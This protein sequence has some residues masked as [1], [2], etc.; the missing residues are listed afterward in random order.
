M[1]THSLEWPFITLSPSHTSLSL[2]HSG[3]FTPL[4]L[5]SVLVYP[6]NTLC[7]VHV[8]LVCAWTLNLSFNF[9]NVSLFLLPF[10]VSRVSRASPRASAHLLGHCFFSL[11]FSL[12]LG[13]DFVGLSA[14]SL[15][16]VYGFS[17]FKFRIE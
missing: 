10:P 6:Y 3:L 11:S 9:W 17:H 15:A 12:S 4:S 14:S 13:F 7:H 2:S 8:A 1:I 5:V 16:I